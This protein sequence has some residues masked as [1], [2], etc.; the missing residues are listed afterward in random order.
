MENDME[1]R[2][3]TGRME[4]YVKQRM[5]KMEKVTDTHTGT[6]NLMKMENHL[7]HFVIEMERWTLKLI[8]VEIRTFRVLYFLH[9]LVSNHEGEI[10][11]SRTF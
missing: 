2:P 11:L 10:I 9:E 7:K 8:I 4:K 5:S 1:S 6:L 3:N